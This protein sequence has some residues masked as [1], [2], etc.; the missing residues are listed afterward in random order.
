MADTDPPP[1]P[2]AALA[3][4]ERARA[5]TGSAL[6][7]NLVLMHAVWGLAYLLAGVT[8][9]LYLVGTLGGAT[10]A[11]VA[12]GIGVAAIV[13]S[14]TAS[15]RSA[16][17]VRSASDTSSAL[18]GFSWLI[19]MALTTL[20]AIGV[21]DPALTPVL[22]VFVVGL[23]MLTSGVVWP[24][25][26]QYVGGSTIMAVAVAAVFVPAPAHILLLAIGGGGAL[27]GVGAVF[28][29]RAPRP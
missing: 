2:A 4:I 24:N 17:G 9:Y 13:T 19:A 5:R 11:V 14:T 7:P 27:L 25:T 1:D 28:A 12:A 26:A 20:M 18:Y 23:L 10:T 15:M 8:Y 29:M 16:R 3:I 21:G 22:F 6:A